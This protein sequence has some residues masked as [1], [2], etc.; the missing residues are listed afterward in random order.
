[1]S[2]HRSPAEVRSSLKH[3]IIDGDGHW[4]EYDPVFAERMRK[5]GGDKAADGY[6]TAMKTTKDALKMSV[7]ERKRR[8][9]A[10]PGFWSRQAEMTLDRATT[11][12]PRLL[13]DRLDELGSDF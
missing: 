13:Y 5:V 1:M 11:M 4:V 9:V 6:L 3:P 8:R 10:M 7:A 2:S 12:M